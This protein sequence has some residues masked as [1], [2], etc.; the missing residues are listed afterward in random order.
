MKFYRNFKDT[1]FAL[2]QSVIEPTPNNINGKYQTFS[3]NANTFTHHICK[4]IEQTPKFRME[5]SFIHS[6][7]NISHGFQLISKLIILQILTITTEAISN[8]KT[9]QNKDDDN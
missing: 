9:S 5:N 8:F 2:F 3:S 6:C 4:L 1:D 7:S